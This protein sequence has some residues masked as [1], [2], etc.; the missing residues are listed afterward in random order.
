[1]EI[2]ELR[3]CHLVSSLTGSFHMA[4]GP[5]GIL[6]QEDGERQDL[7]LTYELGEQFFHSLCGVESLTRGPRSALEKAASPNPM[8]DPISIF[9]E[10]FVR[11]RHLYLTLGQLS[12]C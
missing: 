5:C 10:I 2:P 11:N 12:C 7:C 3:G 8:C 4:L 9:G 1:M 6:G